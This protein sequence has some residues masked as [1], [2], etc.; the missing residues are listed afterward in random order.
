M[1]DAPYGGLPP[2]DR[3]LGEV[4]PEGST[5]SDGLG[6]TTA[7]D[8]GTA[9]TA[10]EQA[11]QVGQTA[12]DSGQ[13]VAGTAT[14]QGKNVLHESK[15]QA[16]NLAH[17]VTQQ[18]HEQSSVQ[19]D[20]ATGSLRGLGAELRGLT[21]DG[22]QRPGVVTDLARQAATKVDELAGWLDQREPGTLVEELR[23]LARRKPGTFLLGA[24][25]A[26]V[27][28][29][30]MTRGAVDAARSDDT[31]SDS[32]YAGYT[33]QPTDYRSD[34]DYQLGT[35]TTIGLPNETVGSTTSTDYTNSSAGGYR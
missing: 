1:T 6:S 27:V 19:K 15:Q 32:R 26:G 5:Y 30:R 23:G 33:T 9:G 31:D 20:K 28:A 22:E 29:G 34:A 12:K 3:P 4:Q 13:R 7:T 24:L 25:A 10:R 18:V 8:N 16:R 35:D 21:G 2:T 17:Q 14:E 11:G